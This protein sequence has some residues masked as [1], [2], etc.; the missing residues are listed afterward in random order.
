VSSKKPQEKI[1]TG[2]WGK[3]ET[4]YTISGNVN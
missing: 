4:S 3:K 1:S 2:M